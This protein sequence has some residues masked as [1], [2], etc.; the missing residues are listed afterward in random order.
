VVLTPGQ[1]HEQTVFEEL[2]A[3]PALARRERGRPRLRPHAVVGD[4]GYSSHRIRAGLHRRGIRA[5]IPH[6]VN[7]HRTGPFDRALYRE[8]NVVERCI[9]RLKQCRRIAT[10]YEKLAD[11]FLAMVT[12]AC[13]LQWL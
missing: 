6:K 7:E 11:H 12:V 8:R 13:I 1:R 10:R 5:V 9:N 3:G 2:L 4:K